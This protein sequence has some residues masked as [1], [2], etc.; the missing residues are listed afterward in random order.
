MLCD[1][2]T[3]IVLK[4]MSNC[5]YVLLLNNVLRDE[6]D[7]EKQ[8]VTERDEERWGETRRGGMRRGERERGE[9]RGGEGERGKEK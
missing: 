3:E 8:G 1:Q 7:G 4:E 6:R 2:D 5:G 9:R